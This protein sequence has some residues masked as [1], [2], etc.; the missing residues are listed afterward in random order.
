MYLALKAARSLN[1]DCAVS[2]SHDETGVAPAAVMNE[3]LDR[4]GLWKT[5]GQA[6]LRRMFGGFQLS[7]GKTTFQLLYGPVRMMIPESP[8]LYGFPRSGRGPY[9]VPFV[10]C[11][12]LKS[13]ISSLLPSNVAR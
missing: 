3:H 11:L 7:D 9:P 10:R 2:T 13:R 8:L 5:K 1:N 6:S 4:A 12:K